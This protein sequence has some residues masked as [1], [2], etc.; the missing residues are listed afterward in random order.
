[1]VAKRYQLSYDVAM[2]VNMHLRDVPDEVHEEL[3]RRAASEGMTLRH[4]TLKVLADHCAVPTLDEWSA[5]MATRRAQWLAADRHAT[6]DVVAA[7]EAGRDE[8]YG[9]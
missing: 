9:T 5:R 8:M 7:V 4:Y 2:S 3:Q 1:M 6:I